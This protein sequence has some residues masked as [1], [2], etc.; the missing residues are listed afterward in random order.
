MNLSGNPIDYLFAF[1]GGIALSFTPCVYPLIPISASYIGIK[2]NDSKLKGLSLSLIYVTG[3]AVTYSLLGLVAS[4]T[5]KIFGMISE[6]PLTNI[7]VGMIILLFGASMLEIFNFPTMNLIK[8]PIFKKRSFLSTFLLGLISGFIVSPCV[9]PAL[10]AILVYLTTKRNIL[11]GM[12]LLLSFAYGM[13]LILVL[14]GTF[15][16]ILVNLPKSGKWLGY[17]KKIGALI[18]IGMGIYFI[19]SGIRRL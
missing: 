2:A 16:S 7:F 12:T 11:Y 10:G 9:T 19:F 17:I 18:L 3:V 6:H 1:L 5:G 13:G 15:S 14:T 4:L 8:I